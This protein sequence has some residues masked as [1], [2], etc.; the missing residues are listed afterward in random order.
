M[1]NAPDNDLARLT[2]PGGNYLPAV[3]ST[4]PL[5]HLAGQVARRGETMLAVG[6]VGKDVDLE[7]AKSCSRQCA[8]NLLSHIRDHAGGLQ[9]VIRVVHVGVYVAAVA[10]FGEHS[11]IAD[12]A[13]EVFVE[14]LGDRGLHTRTAVGVQSLPRRSP[15]EVDCMVE[16]VAAT[17]AH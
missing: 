11:L 5:L 1:P 4:G 17:R 16:L 14:A 7:L 10:D 9:T 6:L 13:S 2:Q 15:V 3:S 12:A 8:L